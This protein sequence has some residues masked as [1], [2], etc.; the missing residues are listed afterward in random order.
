MKNE[1]AV[2]IRKRKI[3]FPSYLL[4][5]SNLD[6]WPA[7]SKLIKIEGFGRQNRQKWDLSKAKKI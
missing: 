2:W 6:L 5:L 4:D 1:Q 7:A 3:I